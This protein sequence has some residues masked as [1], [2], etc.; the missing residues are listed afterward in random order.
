MSNNQP[1]VVVGLPPMTHKKA[2][3]I[4]IDLEQSIY[5]SD[6]PDVKAALAFAKACI[7]CDRLNLGGLES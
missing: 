7:I 1:P 4:L 2:L 5:T 6:S 3:E